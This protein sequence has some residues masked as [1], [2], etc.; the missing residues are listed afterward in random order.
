MC[1][2]LPKNE[3]VRGIRHP[4]I[5]SARAKVPNRGMRH[6]TR[7]HKS[8]L[9]NGYTGN[10][11][12]LHYEFGKQLEVIYLIVIKILL[13]PKWLE[14]VSPEMDFRVCV[15]CVFF[16]LC[17]TTISEITGR[18]DN[19]V[20]VC[21]CVCFEHL[22]MVYGQY[23]IVGIFKINVRYKRQSASLASAKIIVILLASCPRAK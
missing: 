20:I 1:N 11:L 21:V 23:Y 19:I 14:R 2:A 15:C 17:W 7:C 12:A 4:Q 18:V 13:H 16:L 9:A 5:A 22:C 8:E 3:Y 6:T 10:A